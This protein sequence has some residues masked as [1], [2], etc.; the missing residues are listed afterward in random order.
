M[1]PTGII[2]AGGKSSRMGQDKGL[3]EIAGKKLVEIAISNLIP[4]CQR[5]LIS[6][7]STVYEQFG[8]E[9]VRDIFPGIGPM[10]GIYSALK[11]SHS[12]FN[13]VL[14][15][16]LPFAGEDLFRYLLKQ[17]EGYQ[18]AV[19]CSGSD[20]YEPLCACYSISVL[21]QIEESIRKENFKLPDLFREFHMNALTIDSQLPFFKP[22]IFH[23]VNS[24]SDLLAANKLMDIIF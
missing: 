13:L 15:V 7:N 18:V 4:V 9:V 3:L 1:S 10:G 12:E 2:L 17:A 16:D 20:Y 21:P 14:S 8:L 6:S 24:E 19:P 23:N 11:M 22:W 5:I